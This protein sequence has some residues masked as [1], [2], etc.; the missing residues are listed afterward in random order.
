[1]K[2]AALL[3][4]LPIAGH[5]SAGTITYTHDAAGRLTTANYGSGR[6]IGYTYDPAGNL[7]QLTAATTGSTDSDG[8][9]MDDAWE[10][11]YFGNLSRN[12]SGDFDND[13]FRDSYEFF[14]GTN[15]TNSTSALRLL[16]RPVV[17]GGDTLVE[18]QSVSGRM[19]RLQFKNTLTD[20][21]WQAVS[22]D[23]TAT[24]A[25]ASKTDPTSPGQPRRL[26]RVMLVP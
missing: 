21:T 9:G 12:G 5:V 7:T 16:S 8:D 18:W 3:L 4:F 11:A 2:I 24:G 26:Y 1:M 13:G 10:L 22:G 15:P 19:Y 23:V 6:T 20:A 25:T 17:S 14:A